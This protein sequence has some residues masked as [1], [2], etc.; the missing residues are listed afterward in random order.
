[1]KRTFDSFRQVRCGG[2]TAPISSPFP[3]NLMRRILV[4]YARSQHYQKRG[5]SLQRVTLDGDALLSPAPAADVVALDDAL[6]QLA[7]LDLRKSRVV[8]LRFFGGLT[9]DETAE[10]LHLSSRT[11]LSDWSFAKSWLLRELTTGGNHEAAA[12]QG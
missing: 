5:G 12:S 1:M 4:D 10:V 7:A 6:N 3:A 11:V 9:V 2:R 8:E